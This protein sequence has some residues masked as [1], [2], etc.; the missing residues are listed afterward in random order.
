[1]EQLQ[2]LIEK[3]DYLDDF[4]KEGVSFRKYPKDGLMIIKRKYGLSYSED[5]DK[6]WL[7]YCRGLVIDYNNH[8]IV[9]I[10][11]VKSRE[12]LTHDEFNDVCNN[13][14]NELVDGTMMNLFFIENKWVISTRSNIG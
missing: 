3:G 11:P 13:E 10:P 1:M 12:I 8:K 4:K 5:E 9:F 7:N 6:A 14:F 2:Q